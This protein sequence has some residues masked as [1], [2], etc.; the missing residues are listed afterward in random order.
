M[1]IYLAS[2]ARR[3]S[4]RSEVLL[5]SL[6]QALIEWNLPEYVDILDLAIKDSSDIT[7]IC[8]KMILEF[9]TGQHL[10]NLIDLNSLAKNGGPKSVKLSQSIARRLGSK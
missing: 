9:E 1:N 6:R 2:F 10:K 3:R 5:R 8:K 4:E 7:N